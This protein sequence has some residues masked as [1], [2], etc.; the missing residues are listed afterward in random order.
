MD[1]LRLG[2]KALYR[3]RKQETAGYPGLLQAQ[4]TLQM[5]RFRNS[6]RK[7]MRP[8]VPTLRT[9]VTGDTARDRPARPR[10]Y[11]RRPGQG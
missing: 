1:D 2:A 3:N 5:P 9:V 8:A 10:A 11:G 7:R 4:H 6:V